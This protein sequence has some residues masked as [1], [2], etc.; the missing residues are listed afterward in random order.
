MVYYK[1][2]RQGRPRQLKTVQV[3]TAVVAVDELLFCGVTNTNWLPGPATRPAPS[4]A[5]DFC[6]LNPIF[7]GRAAAASEHVKQIMMLGFDF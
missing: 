1:T 5:N 2:A 6:Y 4:D 3:R 7:T